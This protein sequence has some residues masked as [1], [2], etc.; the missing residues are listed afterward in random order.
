MMDRHSPAERK[1]PK[2]NDE[3]SYVADYLMSCLQELGLDP[4]AGGAPRLRSLPNV[5]HLLTPI[6]AIIP[7]GLHILDIADRIHPTPAVSGS[8]VED[9]KQ[10]ISGNEDFKRGPYAG[11]LGFFNAEGEGELTVG[12][13]SA[14][15][16]SGKMRLFAGAGIVNGSDASAEAEEIRLKLKALLQCTDGGAGE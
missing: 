4:I 8:P 10:W 15:I 11:C 7:K 14:L 6:E 9:A 13:R 3:H 2:N 5:Q 12:I 16:Q 1:V